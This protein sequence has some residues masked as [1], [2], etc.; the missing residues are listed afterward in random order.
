MPEPRAL[1]DLLARQD[2]LVTLAQAAQTGLAERTLRSWVAAGRWERVAPRVFL[3]GGHPFTDRARVRAAGLWAGDQGLVCGPAAAWWYGMLDGSP[4]VVRIT[5]P[6]ARRLR[7]IPGVE[8]R[9]RDIGFADRRV[10]R[11]LRLTDRPLTVLET[12]VALP[13]ASEFFDRAL[14]KHVRIEQLYRAHHR[15]IG[16]Y[17]GARMTEL[18]TAAA[19]RADSAAERLM[20]AILRGS[21]IRGWV[22]HHPFGIWHVDFAVPASKVAIEVDGWAWHVAPDR[23]RNDRHKGN[24]LVRAG[25]VLLRFTWHD[26]VNR[27]G[28]V[29]AEITAAL[30]PRPGHQ[31]P[32]QPPPPL[33]VSQSW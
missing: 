32:A 29:L 31:R 8:V 3:V 25:W 16:A 15:A 30:H 12:T 19:D 24:A 20:L 13:D 1:H 28:Y 23:F 26:L 2:G 21:T 6:R 7:P 33:R 14:Q 4:D 17:G 11:G 9:R 22:R 27:P 5:V 18:L 10:V